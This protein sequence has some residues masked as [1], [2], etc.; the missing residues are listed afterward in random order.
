[1]K[2]N[3]GFNDVIAGQ[4]CLHD[5]WV[6]FLSAASLQPYQMSDFWHIWAVLNFYPVSVKRGYDKL[7]TDKTSQADMS[8][9]DKSSPCT[10]TETDQPLV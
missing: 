10:P 7:S 5:R 1:M 3:S 6:R 9:A 4:Q 2:N 8:H